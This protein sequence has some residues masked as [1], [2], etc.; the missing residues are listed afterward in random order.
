MNILGN[1]TGSSSEWCWFFQSHRFLLGSQLEPDAAT[2]PF[3]FVSFLFYFILFLF[4]SRRRVKE[5][6][7]F[8]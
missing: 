7:L 6:G 1:D 4:S 3:L 8:M 2:L 5:E